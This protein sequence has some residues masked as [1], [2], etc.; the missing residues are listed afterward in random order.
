M[1]HRVK[2]HTLQAR[3]IGGSLEAAPRRIAVRMRERFGITAASKLSGVP[4]AVFGGSEAL[5]RSF[6]QALFTADGHVAGTPSHGVSVRSL[7]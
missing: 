3:A 4:D 5:Q 2:R 1:T 6:L 7:A